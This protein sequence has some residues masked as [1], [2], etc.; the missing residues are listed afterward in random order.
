MGRVYMHS[1]D[2]IR[3]LRDK[4]VWIDRVQ[5]AWDFRVPYFRVKALSQSVDKL[6]YWKGSAWG[7][8]TL[9]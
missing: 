8:G 5:S 9:Y 6:R 3:E 4:R 2:A 1:R 7:T